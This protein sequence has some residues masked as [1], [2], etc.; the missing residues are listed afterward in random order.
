M[1]NSH[2]KNVEKLFASEQQATIN[3]DEVDQDN[4][5]E[6]ELQ[7]LK[8]DKQYQQLMK[9]FA[10]Q[11]PSKGNELEILP[12]YQ[13]VKVTKKQLLESQQTDQSHKPSLSIP[14]RKATY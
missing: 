14:S 3:I 4:L 5:D 2:R 8:E 6:I 10:L 12:R 13:G 9:D 11:G 1:S 7:N